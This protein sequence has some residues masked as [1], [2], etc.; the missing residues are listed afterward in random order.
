MLQEF[1]EFSKEHFNILLYAITLITSI[2]HYKKY[3]DTALKY[4]PII[5]AYTF[6]NELLGYFIRYT[7]TF[8]FFSSESYN[9]EIIYNLYMLV[10]FGFFY[11]IYWILISNKKFKKGIVYISILG[12]ISFAINSYFYNPINWL[13]YYTWSLASIG[14]LIC[15]VLYWIDKRENWKWKYER[16]NLMTWVSIGLFLFYIFF[17]II[18]IIGYDYVQLFEKLHLRTVLRILIVIMY[19]LFCIGFVKSHRRAFR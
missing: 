2:W 11:H 5:I 9:N 3:Y 17:P 1:I 4:F 19:L 16:F 8:A 14:L 13:L 12:L 18:F 15:I 6:F 7:D 10:F